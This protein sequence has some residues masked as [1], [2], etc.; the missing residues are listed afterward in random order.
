MCTFLIIFANKLFGTM[1]KAAFKLDRTSNR[2]RICP[3]C[4]TEHMVKH[5]GR[6]FCCDKCADD[7]YNQNRR[8][9]KQAEA[10]LNE[11]KIN[12]TEEITS[13]E[14]NNNLI[15]AIKENDLNWEAAMKVNLSVLNNLLLDDKHGSVFS[16]DDLIS[17]GLNFTHHSTQGI[18]HNTPENIQ[19]KFLIFRNYRVYRVDYNKVL[20]KKN[21]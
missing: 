1:K 4:G 12:T 14:P 2:F 19:S 16:I 7:Y 9:K 3:N 15:E 21:I 13:P 11:M 8:L 10:M 6:D 18:N 20:V 5:L 17:L